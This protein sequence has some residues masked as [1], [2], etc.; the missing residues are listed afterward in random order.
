MRHDVHSV[1]LSLSQVR[2]V[3]AQRQLRRVPVGLATLAASGLRI[4]PTATAAASPGDGSDN[5][6]AS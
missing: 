4:D 1:G 5:G 6:W 3:R 2:E